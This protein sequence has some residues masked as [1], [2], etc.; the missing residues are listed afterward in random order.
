MNRLNV[1]FVCE[2]LTKSSIIAQP[3]KHVFEI[4]R[5][6]MKQGN[7]VQILTDRTQGLPS[8]EEIDGVMIRRIRKGRFLF[9]REQLL[10]SLN[11]GDADIINWHGSDTWSAVQFWRLRESIRKNIVW[12]LHSGILSM[13][14]LKNLNPLEF[15]QLYK[16]WNNIFNA[17]IPKRFV[18]RWV[19]VP[20][21]RHVITLSKRTAQK[22]KDYGLSE[23]NVTPIPSG[24]DVNLF[25]PL[26]NTAEDFTILYFGPLSSFRGVDVLL[27]AFKL[28]RRSLPSVRLRLLAREPNSNS[29]WFRKAEN[30]ANVDVITGLLNQKELVRHLSHASVVVLPFKFWPQVECPLTILE[31]MAMEKTVVT[32]SMG[33]IP[34]IIR[35]W[36][37]GLLVPPKNSKQLAEVVVKLLNDPSQC[38]KIGRKARTYIEH[39]HDWNKIVEE[40]LGVLLDSLK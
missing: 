8:E 29:Y 38:E 14:D 25:K 35:N 39:F 31:A 20:F 19:R 37:N 33:A 26:G 13:E 2:G 11:S 9:D 12:T 15:F 5:R 3:W 18:R 32:T 27:S 1:L 30:L 17:M 22:L 40:T 16:F 34:E 10:E 23:E 24:V 6:M 7:D 21:L 4:A 36:E 28:V